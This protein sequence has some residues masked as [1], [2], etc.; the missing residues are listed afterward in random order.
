MSLPGSSVPGGLVLRAV[1]G[2][3]VPAPERADLPKWPPRCPVPWPGGGVPGFGLAVGPQLVR[4]R[5]FGFAG[6]ASD[7]WKIVVSFMTSV[8]PHPPHRIKHPFWHPLHP[9][10]PVWNNLDQDSLGVPKCR[11]SALRLILF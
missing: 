7:L 1:D 9:C 4:R 6:W 11:L 2:G 8:P 5:R 10:N 3:S